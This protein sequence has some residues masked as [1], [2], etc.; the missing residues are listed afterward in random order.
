MN[1]TII[2]FTF[3]LGAIIGSFLNVVILR[4]PHNRGIARGRSYCPACQHELAWWQ[5]IPIFS[6]MG[7]RGKCFWCRAGISWQYPAVELLYGLLFLAV[8]LPGVTG[9]STVMDWLVIALKAVILALLLVLAVIDLRL[10]L[11]P[12]PYVLALAAASAA[13]IFFTHHSWLDSFYGALAGGGFIFFLWLITKGK[14]IGFGDVKLMAPLGFLLG[15]MPTVALLFSAFMIG[16]LVGGF[17]LLRRAASLK[18]AIPFGPFLIG[19]A[20]VFLL[21][22]TLPGYL[23]SLLLGA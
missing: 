9:Q 11:L 14:G 2:F 4:Y 3:F 12:D 7:L 6:Y 23:V 5:L 13:F 19:V 21:W 15:L 18:T 17:L 10:F 22:P 1:Y 16:G 20:A 8:S